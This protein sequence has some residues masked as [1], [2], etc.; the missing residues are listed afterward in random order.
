MMTWAS[1]VLITTLIS[2]WTLVWFF[3]GVRCG[4]ADIRV[5]IAKAKNDL[6]EETQK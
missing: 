3:L 5:E 6:T 2:G 4:R 1:M